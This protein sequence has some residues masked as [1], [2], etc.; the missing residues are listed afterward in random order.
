MK[1]AIFIVL[2]IVIFSIA[3]VLMNNKKNKT[4]LPQQNENIVATPTPTPTPAPIPKV[5][6]TP[7]PISRTFDIIYSEGKMSQQ[8]ITVSVGDTVR[9]LN[10]DNNFHWPASGPHPTHQICL[11][12]DSLKGL[13]NGETYSFTFQETKECPF[14]DHLNADAAFRGKIIVTE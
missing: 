1:K 3:V 8:N 4:S 6:V 14:H 13:A 5:S 12:F 7:T 11:G 9:F 10:N 2:L